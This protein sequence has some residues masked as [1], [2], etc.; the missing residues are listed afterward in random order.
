MISMSNCRTVAL[1]KEKA[2][3]PTM[4]RFCLS[5]CAFTRI[6]EKLCEFYGRKIQQ[7]NSRS[8]V[9]T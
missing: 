2:G 4:C 3:E 7:Q 1:L 9:Q 5:R 8:T 6:V